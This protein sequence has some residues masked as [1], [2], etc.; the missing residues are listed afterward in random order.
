MLISNV[1]VS[2]LATSVGNEKFNLNHSES[3]VKKFWISSS[4]RKMLICMLQKQCISCDCC[5]K[6]FWK[7]FF[8]NSLAVLY[9][10]VWSRQF[11]GVVRFLFLTTNTPKTS[12]IVISWKSLIWRETVYLDILESG[13]SR[14]VRD[15]HPVLN[16]RFHTELNKTQMNPN[17]ILHLWVISK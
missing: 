12:R 5:L 7:A 2:T 13:V 6:P 1:C 8:T 10:V 15:T 14:A 17:P 9:H 11:F 3:D 4:D 16:Y